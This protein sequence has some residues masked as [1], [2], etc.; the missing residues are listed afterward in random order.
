ML[1]SEELFPPEYCLAG[2]CSSHLARSTRLSPLFTLFSFTSVPRIPFALFPTFPSSSRSRSL[3]FTRRHCFNET[4]N[5]Q[6]VC[7]APSPCRDRGERA[8]FDR[9]TLPCTLALSAIPP[10][11]STLSCRAHKIR[12]TCSQAAGAARSYARASALHRHCSRL[13]LWSAVPAWNNSFFSPFFLKTRERVAPLHLLW[14]SWRAGREIANKITV[15][16]GRRF[17]SVFASRRDLI[18]DEKNTEK[19]VR[20][21]YS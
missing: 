20:C 8:V 21:Y 17:V 4:G 16:F 9:Y 19:Y 15:Q 7:P 3:P 6:F 11:L 10:G 18:D 2:S 5:V 13:I 1:T 12:P 14:V